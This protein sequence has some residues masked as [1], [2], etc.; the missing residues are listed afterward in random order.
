MEEEV[1]K[2]LLKRSFLFLK[3]PFRTPGLPAFYPMGNGDYFS[4]GKSDEA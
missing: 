4:R 2:F 1:I 3:A